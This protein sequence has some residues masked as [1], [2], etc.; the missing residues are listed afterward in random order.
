MIEPIGAEPTAPAYL[1]PDWPAPSRVRAVSTLRVG[2]VSAPPFDS[3]NLA[4]HVD[5]DPEAVAANR[6]RLRRDLDLPGE[7][8][9]LDQVHGC[10]VHVADG[11]A[12][13][14]RA[15]AVVS[16]EPGRVCVVMTADCLP[17]LLCDRSGN[18][19]AAVHAGWRGLAEGVIGA[20]VRAL[21]SNPRD[22]LAWLGPAIGPEAFEVGGEV[23]AA[24]VALDPFNGDG[25]RPSPAGRWLAD[26]KFLAQR[27]LRAL[28]VHAVY[29]GAGCTFTERE[30]FFSYRRDRR[31]GRMASLIWLAG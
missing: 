13:G 11:G 16:G 29:D 5:D 6:R 8:V 14:G 10:A 7:P 30:R 20:G 27:Q 2:G 21:A 26:I 15:D 22:L 28:G 1:F 24:F 19:V 31:T 23:R 18:R 17:V 25:F 9:W 12:R 4:A 3:F